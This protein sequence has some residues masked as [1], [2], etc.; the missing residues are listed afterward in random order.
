MKNHHVVSMA[1]LTGFFVMCLGCSGMLNGSQSNPWIGQLQ[2]VLQESLGE[3]DAT[4]LLTS[5]EWRLIW[6]KGQGCIVTVFTTPHA[7]ITST[8]TSGCEGTPYDVYSDQRIGQETKQ[9]AS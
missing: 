9:R 7:R 4:D 5:G 3:P 8:R 2:P 1:I 6:D